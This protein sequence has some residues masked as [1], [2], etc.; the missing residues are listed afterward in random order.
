MTK[1]RVWDRILSALM[2]IL[3]ILGAAA[4]VLYAVGWL[5]VFLWCVIGCFY[6]LD[7]TLVLKSREIPVFNGP[8]QLI[9]S[10]TDKFKD[11]LFV[12]T[13]IAR[14]SKEKK[15]GAAKNI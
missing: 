14:G 15:N 11:I 3:C 5:P 4:L 7:K 13:V 9:F 6:V 10:F 12:G 2:G 1:L 8:F